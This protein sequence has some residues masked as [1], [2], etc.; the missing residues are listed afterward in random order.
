MFIPLMTRLADVWPDL[1]SNLA[2]KANAI[3]IF[4]YILTG[5]VD[6]RKLL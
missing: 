6:H 2:A 1:E 3:P 5:L 4:Y